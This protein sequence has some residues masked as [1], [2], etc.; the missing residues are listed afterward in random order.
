MKTPNALQL[1]ALSLVFIS[2]SC[3]EK[4]S[5]AAENSNTPQSINIV[6]LEGSNLAFSNNESKM[7]FE[8]Y[9]LLGN[10]LTKSDLE[11]AKQAAADLASLSGDT[12][13]YKEV[14]ALIGASTDIESQRT[15]FSEL[16]SVVEPMIKDQLAKGKV[17]KQFCPMAF[18]NDGA[19]WFSAE[20]KIRNPYFGDKMLTCGKITETIEN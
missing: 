15:L 2:L 16:T 10:A 8:N 1:A 19:Y 9:I 12:S 4:T 3:K 17:Y 11:G 20:A 18:N 14:A 13:S 6:A 5:T 7:V